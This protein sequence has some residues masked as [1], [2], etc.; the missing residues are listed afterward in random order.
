MLMI[1]NY[2]FIQTWD[3]TVPVLNSGSPRPPAEP[4]PLPEGGIA[5]SACAIRRDEVAAAGKLFRPAALQPPH[6]CRRP[7]AALPLCQVECLAAREAQGPRALEAVA[8][9]NGAVVP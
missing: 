5:L 7:M 3:V 6:L 4:H 9:P 1:T 8:A 2:L